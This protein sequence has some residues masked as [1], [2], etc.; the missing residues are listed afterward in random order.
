MPNKKYAVNVEEMSKTPEMSSLCVSC[1]IYVDSGAFCIE[2]DGWWHYSCGQTTESAVKKLGDQEFVCPDHRDH[3]GIEI[4]IA[5]NV[6]TEEGEDTIFPEPIDV[7]TPVAAATMGAEDSSYN[8]CLE[9]HSNCGNGVIDTVMEDSFEDEG[10]DNEN[11]VTQEVDELNEILEKKNSIIIELEA[12]LEREKEKYLIRIDHLM[13]E[14][15]DIKEDSKKMQNNSCVKS[16][17]EKLSGER[18]KLNRLEKDLNDRNKTISNLGIQVSK[19]QTANTQLKQKNDTL[20]ERIDVLR[21]TN[22]SLESTVKLREDEMIAV[23]H[24]SSDTENAK[25]E[26]LVSKC[27]VLENER[28]NLINRIKSLEKDLALVHAE[29]SQEESLNFLVMSVKHLRDLLMWVLKELTM[30][31]EAIQ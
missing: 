3:K 31:K 12:E 22:E 8:V 24:G 18:C 5:L 29:K 14:N 27:S 7:C 15:N 20:E 13:K 11:S 19:L 26:S 16:L 2:C 21:A 6:P 25:N 10:S 30:Q 17:K 23:R 4:E 28:E 9:G 1:K